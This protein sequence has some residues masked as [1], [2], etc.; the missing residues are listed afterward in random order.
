MGNLN[1]PQHIPSSPGVYTFKDRRGTPIYIGKAADLKKRLYSYWRKDVSDKI[2]TMLKEA[3]RVEW[4]EAESEVNAL[5]KEAE[6]I[7][8]HIPKYNILQRD[9]KNYFYV[10]ITIKEEYPKIF[11]THQPNRALGARRQALGLKHLRPKAYNL[12]PIYIGP[13]TSGSA[14]KTTLRLLRNIFPFCTCKDAHKRPCLNAEIGRC[15]RYCCFKSSLRYSNVLENIRIPTDAKN[16]YGKNIR[17]IIG[18]L[19]G[20]KKKISKE[21]K[22]EMNQ[23]VKEENFERA[24]KLRDQIAG[25]E[26]VLSHS[27]V[28]VENI[29]QKRFLNWPKIQ[30]TLKVFLG[31]EIRRVEGYDISNI[32]GTEATGS[33][34]VFINGMPAKHE[35]RKFKIKTIAGPNDVAMHAEVMRRRLGHIE[36]KYPDL[37]L[38][39]GG[40]AQINA[41]VS[42]INNQLLITGNRPLVAALAKREEELY[43]EGRRS[44]LRISTLPP[45]VAFFFQRIRDESHRFARKYHL[46]RREISYR[47][48]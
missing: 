31:K 28:L 40:R 8:A 11:L 2:R 43:I 7:K 13:F 22:R 6:L 47:I 35:Y 12:K 37:M 4:A 23:F 19:S 15:P 36:W 20:K 27:G 42:V 45:D 48:R 41:V 24:A 10:G 39:D 3:A 18:V 5:I 38:I 46:K 16:E 26:N 14:L 30:K 9:D 29:S 25:L 21:L 17:N 33:M 1:K 34:A 32:S 44:P